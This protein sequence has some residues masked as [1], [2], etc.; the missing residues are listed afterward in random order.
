M[1]K[2][3]GKKTSELTFADEHVE[4][5]VEMELMGENIY[6]H[7]A[8]KD[9]SVGGIMVPGSAA[10]RTRFGVIKGLGPDADKDKFA[11]GDVVAIQFHVGSWLNAPAFG[12]RDQ[13]HIICTQHNIM[14][15]LHDKE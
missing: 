9:D 11:V 8:E 14:F 7:L 5:Q 10:Q 12:F 6:I 2:I 4:S 3:K 1:E 15:K 13:S